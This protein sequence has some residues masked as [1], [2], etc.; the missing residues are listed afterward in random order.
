VESI[1][2]IEEDTSPQSSKESSPAV[3][4]SEPLLNGGDHGDDAAAVPSA[5][6]SQPAVVDVVVPMKEPS[7]LSL[8]TKDD[9]DDEG[10]E[11]IGAIQ[12]E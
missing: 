9:E 1:G 2:I 4:A 7:P 10:V 11:V 6:V 12:E 5:A 8:K 3:V